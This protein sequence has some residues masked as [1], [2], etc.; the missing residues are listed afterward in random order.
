M[1]IEKA[2]ETMFVQ[3]ICMFN[4]DE[5]DHRFHE[6]DGPNVDKLKAVSNAKKQFS[7]T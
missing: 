7:F 6:M 5:I 3:K 1:Y 4:V 2:G